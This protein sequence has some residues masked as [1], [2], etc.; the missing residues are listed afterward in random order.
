MSGVPFLDQVRDE[1]HLTT[2]ALVISRLSEMGCLTD[3]AAGIEGR[4]LASTIISN[5]AVSASKGDVVRS[6]AGAAA[7]LAAQVGK[8]LG[9]AACRAGQSGVGLVQPKALPI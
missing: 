2:V 9:D 5:R 1:Q 7:S 8:V 4:V 6:V 3:E